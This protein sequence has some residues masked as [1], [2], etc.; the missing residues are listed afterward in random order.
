[1]EEA[2]KE[3]PNVKLAEGN[4]RERGENLTALDVLPW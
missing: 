4:I 1:M 3:M 2:S